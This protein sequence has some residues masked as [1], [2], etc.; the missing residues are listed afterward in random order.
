VKV[1]LALITMAITAV[2][3][4]N[5]PGETALHFLEKVRAKNLNLAPGADTALSPQTSEAKRKEIARRI[6]RIARDLG[7]DPL[8]VGA[9]KLD[10]DLAG[11]LVRKISGFDPNRMQIFPIA[12]VKRGTEWT[13]APVPASFENSGV[14][15][16]AALRQRLTVLEDWMLREQVL[17]LAQLRDQSAERMRRKIEEK[18]PAATLRALNYQQVIERFLSATQTRNLPEIYGLLGGLAA[19]LPPDWPSRITAAQNAV[20]A[21]SEAASPWRLLVSNNILRTIVHQEEDSRS[22]LISIVCLDP[23]GSTTDASRPLLQLVHLDLTKSKDGLWRINLPGYFLQKNANAGDEAGDDPD[24]GPDDDLDA[25]LLDAFPAKLSES[26]PATPKPTVEEARKAVMSAFHEGDLS[27]IMRLIDLSGDSKTARESCIRAAQLWWVLRAPSAVR[28]AIPLGLQE[29]RQHAAAAFQF[30]STRNP[31]RLDLQILYFKKSAT[32]WLWAPIPS[33]ESTQPFGEW[34]ELQT[35]KWRDQWQDVLLSDCPVLDKLP[36]ADAPTEEECR[37]L[38]ESWLLAVHAGDITAA[39]RFTARLNLPESKDNLLRNQG[40]ELGDARKN[41]RPPPIIGVYR[42]KNWAAVGTQMESDK[43]PFSPLYSIVTTPS[44]PRILPEID[45]SASDKRSR[46]FLNK[47]TLKRLGKF[48][49]DAAIQLEKLF[50]THQ[51]QVIKP[52]QP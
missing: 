13:A 11:V 37:K 44:G 36:E 12:L 5:D 19:E 14:R 10:G 51:S 47:T 9:V 17:D 49:P 24:D 43:K 38:V 2:A 35:E 46:D 30:F 34:A 18:L 26:C 1:I 3:A 45:L 8:E 25:D 28:R 33:P 6:E 32:G 16:T 4:P 15:H 29:E 21:G 22:A 27:S 50:A 20:A 41:K 42:G 7:D 23:S 48:N 52:E 31:D 39:L 40:Y